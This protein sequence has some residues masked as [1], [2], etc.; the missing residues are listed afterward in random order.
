MKTV[1]T[2]GCLAHVL[3]CVNRREEGSSMPCCARGGDDAE[4]I[5]EAL[6]AWVQAR[7]LLAQVW[8]TRTSCL[9]WCHRDGATLVFYPENRWYR[10]VTLADLPTLIQRHLAPLSAPKA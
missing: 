6:R 4:V 3:I 2:S 10:A 5:Y 8:I 7:G 9:G 1:D